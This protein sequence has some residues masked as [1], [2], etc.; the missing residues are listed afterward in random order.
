MNTTESLYTI[1][2]EQAASVTQV[3]Q[4]FGT[5]RL[6]PPFDALPLA[7]QEGTGEAVVYHQ[8]VDALFYGRPLPDGDIEMHPG[9]TAESLRNCT[10]AHLRSFEPSHQHKIAGV[11]YMVSRLATL[12]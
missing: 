5:T 3:E 2:P 7:F 11:A 8:L 12:M 1:T 10:M 6:L 4:A 9:V